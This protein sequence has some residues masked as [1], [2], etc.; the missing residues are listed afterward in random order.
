M[1]FVFLQ[2]EAERAP[3]GEAEVG[4]E[5][6]GSVQSAGAQRATSSQQ[7]Q[8]LLHNPYQTLLNRIDVHIHTHLLH[9][10]TKYTVIVA[11]EYCNKIWL[12]DPK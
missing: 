10:V 9:N 5:D 1:W 2:G 7:G 12:S 11:E 3:T 6:H 8:V 4:G